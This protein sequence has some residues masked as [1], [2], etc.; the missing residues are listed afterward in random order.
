MLDQ[1]KYAVSR[2]VGYSDGQIIGVS[3][4][5]LKPRSL[6]KGY[7]GVQLPKE[8][9]GFKNFY[10]HHLVYWF[11]TGDDRV[12]DSE[13]EIHHKDK[14]R[15]NNSIEN[16]ELLPAHT[17]R[18]QEATMN[19]NNARIDFETAELIRKIYAEGN[20]SQTSIAEEFG[21]VQQHVSDIVNFNK[22]TQE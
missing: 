6:G 4:K 8:G 17:H 5:T 11:E 3:G 13:Y 18:S 14:N 21:L 1:V 22:W 15:A 9:G 12:F 20:R 19:R 7:R 2:G 16:L 10:V